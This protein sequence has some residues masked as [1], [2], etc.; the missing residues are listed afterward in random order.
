M[1]AFRD[2]LRGRN[3]SEEQVLSSIDLIER[4]LAFRQKTKT[5]A[6]SDITK[7][8]VGLLVS[9]GSDS[10]ENL[11]ALLRYGRFI[12][13]M[14]LGAGVMELLDGAE[15]MTNLYQRLADVE[16]EKV[17][18]KVFD[19]ISIP[20]LGVESVQKAQVMRVVM[21][22]LEEAIGEAKLVYMLSACLRDLPESWYTEGKE[23]YGE[24]GDIAKYLE[25]AA[26][27]FVEELE[28]IRQS[29]TLFFNQPITSEVVDYVRANQEIAS[30]VLRD[31]VIYITKIP[32]MAKEYLS[33]LDQVKKRYLYCHCPWAR[34]SILSGKLV[35]SN[36][37]H[38][39]AGFV[40]KQWEVTLG[41]SLKAE[42]L[43]SALKGD[44]QCRF[45]IKID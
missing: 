38:C 32:Y 9:E 26:H 44:M 12:G 2:Y 22:R 19:G 28:N 42:V 14:E 5:V 7:A 1:K 27:E 8:F 21:E 25:Q 37:C 15:V 29:G 36:F 43:E 24:C 30:G 18:D 41:R 23:R 6:D 40:K 39:S 34:E 31:R 3:C 11:L 35:S 17:R 45:A 10:N 16:G 13:D 20:T 33:E 4:Y